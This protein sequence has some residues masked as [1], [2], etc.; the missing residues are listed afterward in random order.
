MI[1]SVY[2]ARWLSK[3]RLVACK[4]IAVSKAKEAELLQKS[5]LQEIAA[6]ME[7]SGAYILKTYGFAAARQGETK[8]F[9]LITEYMSR[10]S[11]SDVIQQMGEKMSLRR[12]LDMARNIAR[13]NTKDA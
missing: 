1:G 6:Y 13:W 10:G 2:K 4:V 9:M 7:L 12:K 8:I 5:F 11:L 3:N